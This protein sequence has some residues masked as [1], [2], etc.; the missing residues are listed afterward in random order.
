MK[1]HTNGHFGCIVLFVV[2]AIFLTVYLGKNIKQREDRK[3]QALLSDT[4]KQNSA[5]RTYDKIY[6][7]LLTEDPEV[8]ELAEGVLILK[9][10]LQRI[11]SYADEAERLLDDSEEGKYDLDEMRAILE[12]IIEECRQPIN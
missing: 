6:F 4:A 7:Q 12:N 8:Y 3:K 9:D 5:Y 1:D 2:A 10:K 11:H